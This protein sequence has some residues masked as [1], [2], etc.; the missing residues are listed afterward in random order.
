MSDAKKRQA[1][2]QEH[3][4]GVAPRQCPRRPVR[5]YDPGPIFPICPVSLARE[6][7]KIR[8]L[9]TWTRHGIL[10]SKGEY[11]LTLGKGRPRS[12]PTSLCM[13]VGQKSLLLS[14]KGCALGFRRA[15]IGAGWTEGL[16][17]PLKEL[18]QERPESWNRT[19]FNSKAS[20]REKTVYVPLFWSLLINKNWVLGARLSCSSA[21]RRMFRYG[22][23]WL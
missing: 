23:I 5:Q 1:G 13:Y 19:S 18:L 8:A 16:E 10:R 6:L 2:V 20:E 15:A 3:S 11:T 14:F 21:K 4:H 22:L 9:Q 17:P 12:S 7:P